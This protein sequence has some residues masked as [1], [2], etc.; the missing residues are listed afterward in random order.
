MPYYEG[1]Q[2]SSG[3]RSNST[4]KV[5]AWRVLLDSGSDGDLLFERKGSKNSVPYS[6][7]KTTQLWHTKSGHFRT[8][9]QAD[10]EI[11]FPEY[12][13]SKRITVNPDIVY[14]E[15]ESPAPMF[16]LI[17]GT[18]TMERLGIILDFKNTMITIDQMKFPMRDIKKLQS[19]NYH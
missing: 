14:Y 10:L 16:D 2:R 1:Q 3:T 11:I 18:Q 6:G 9:R 8:E 7:R 13:M 15:S 19:N 12:S 17:L 5:N 4:H